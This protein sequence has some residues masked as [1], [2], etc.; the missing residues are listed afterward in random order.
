MAI[1]SDRAGLRRRN[2]GPRDVPRSVDKV[3]NMK[4]PIA[5]NFALPPTLPPPR[6]PPNRVNPPASLEMHILLL[7]LRNN[8][9]WHSVASE[10]MTWTL[11]FLTTQGTAT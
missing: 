9:H 8:A 3:R 11:G 1:R 10:S 5:V 2:G 4:E 7:G 6:E